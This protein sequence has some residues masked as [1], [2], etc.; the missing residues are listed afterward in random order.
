[1]TAPVPLNNLNTKSSITITKTVFIPFEAPGEE[2][3]DKSAV[4][5]DSIQDPDDMSIIASLDEE[6]VGLNEPE[7]HSD[8][9]QLTFGKDVTRDPSDA[10][11]STSLIEELIA[12]NDPEHTSDRKTHSRFRSTLM[13]IRKRFTITNAPSIEIAQHCDTG[14]TA[15]RNTEQEDEDIFEML[16][17]G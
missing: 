4:G 5:E 12:V 3:A 8:V 17:A 11:N 15:D 2:S 13:D 7:P 16:L 1:V 6:Q 10:C 14:G 9:D